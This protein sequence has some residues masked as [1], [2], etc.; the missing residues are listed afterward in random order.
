MTLPWH[1]TCDRTSLD[2]NDHA[3]NGKP[4]AKVQT[5][6]RFSDMPRSSSVCWPYKF[7]LMSH[8]CF[9][10]KCDV[11]G[12]MYL[13]EQEA[14]RTTV[15]QILRRWRDIWSKCKK[16]D[17][18]RLLV[19]YV[20]AIEIDSLSKIISWSRGRVAKTRIMGSNRSGFVCMWAFLCCPA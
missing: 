20:V 14:G 7:W 9:R 11:H 8:P 6:M 17:Y 19:L 15:C 13:T 1:K 18:D 2:G 4:S 5:G 12:G 3:H 10:H 16:T